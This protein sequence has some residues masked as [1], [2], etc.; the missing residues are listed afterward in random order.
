[1][2]HGRL[3][4]LTLGLLL[5]GV[6]LPAHAQALEPTTLTI[7]SVRQYADSTPPLA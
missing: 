4:V 7:D 2:V 3:L 1:M 6:G 5:A